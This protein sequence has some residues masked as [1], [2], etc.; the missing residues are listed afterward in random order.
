MA[1]GDHGHVAQQLVEA[2]EDCIGSSR[3]PGDLIPVLPRVVG[4]LCIT[5]QRNLQATGILLR[6][7]EHKVDRTLYYTHECFVR[8]YDEVA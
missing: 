2:C 4:G 5:K 7:T 1:S 3:S 6:V 8:L